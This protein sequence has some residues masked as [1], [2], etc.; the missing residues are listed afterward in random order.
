MTWLDIKTQEDASTLIFI[1]LAS[2]T[3]KYLI[4]N[5]LKPNTIGSNV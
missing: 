4:Y 5:C 2:N 3:K 1:F